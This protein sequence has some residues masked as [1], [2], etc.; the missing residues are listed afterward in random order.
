LA[1]AYVTTTMDPIV[2]TDQTSETFRASLF[3][4]FVAKCLTK[5]QDREKLPVKNKLT[6]MALDVQRFNASLLEVRGMIMTGVTA[7]DI[8]RIAVARHLGKFKPNSNVPVEADVYLFKSFD[9]YQWPYAGACKILQK[10]PKFNP[11]SI[12]GSP[13]LAEE[14]TSEDET[15][16]PAAGGGAVSNRHGGRGTGSATHVSPAA[17]RCAKRGGK[18]GRRRQR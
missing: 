2:G 12:A 3:K 1:E 15:A 13:L 4:A 11:R 8:F 18:V 9:I 10:I 16:S 17:A 14:T 6:V 5:Y 7:D